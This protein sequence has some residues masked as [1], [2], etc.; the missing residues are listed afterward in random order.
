MRCK[1]MHGRD[2]IMVVKEVHILCG[3]MK[4]VLMSCLGLTDEMIITRFDPG[5]G[6]R[7]K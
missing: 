5:S 2:G 7:D 3:E 4:G 1:E 6:R